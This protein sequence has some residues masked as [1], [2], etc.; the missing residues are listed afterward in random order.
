MTPSLDEIDPSVP[1]ASEKATLANL[2]KAFLVVSGAAVQ[3]FQ[4]KIKDE[5]EVLIAL[6]DAAIQIFAIE[7]AVLRAEKC[8]PRLSPERRALTAAA[9]KVFTFS[10]VEK[11]ASAARRAVFF[12][13]D[14]DMATMMLGGVRRFTK[15]DASGLLEAKK[16]LGAAAVA[17]DKYPL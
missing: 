8:A 11:V 14:G 2:K 15:Y 13:A 10:A 7:S 17:A 1:F 3:K 4:D 6:A 5:Q 9:V 12:V 16:L